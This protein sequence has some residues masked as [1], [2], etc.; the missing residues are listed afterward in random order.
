MPRVNFDGLPCYYCGQPSKTVE[1]LPPRMLVKNFDCDR[2][3]VPSCDVHNTRKSG[4]DQSILSA[5]AIS[6]FEVMKSTKLSPNVVRAISQ[7]KK[8]FPFV[9]RT[10]HKGSF[11][12]SP[13]VMT[14]PPKTA[15]LKAD[16]HEWI[17][18][19]TAGILWDARHERDTLIDWDLVESWTPDIHPMP[20]Q[21]YTRE[22]VLKLM[23]TRFQTLDLTNRAKFVKGW[24]SEP[25]PYPAD[26]YRFELMI[27]SRNVVFRHVFFDSFT[28]YVVLPSID[29]R[30]A[31]AI[32]A[33]IKEHKITPA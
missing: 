16:T 25:K 15:I 1:H 19:L 18:Q 31:A 20:S 6:L 3:T 28:Y 13:G 30:T 12:V 33:K 17:K 11:P 7:I 22:D 26:I 9:V 21:E 10:A 27:E 32:E 14:N 29:S 23:R 24:S 8:A 4:V 2:I 5:Y